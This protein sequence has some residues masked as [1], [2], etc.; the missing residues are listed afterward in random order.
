MTITVDKLTRIEEKKR[1]DRKKN[2]TFEK[3]RLEHWVLFQRGPLRKNFNNPHTR[4]QS[5][6]CSHVTRTNRAVIKSLLTRK[7]I[8]FEADIE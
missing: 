8:D 1:K 5:Y 6:V 3:C 4:A 2:E 7:I